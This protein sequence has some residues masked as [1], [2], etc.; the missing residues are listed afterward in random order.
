MVIKAGC[1]IHTSAHRG[2]TKQKSARQEPASLL[3]AYRPSAHRGQTD[4]APSKDG[5]RKEAATHSETAVPADPGKI[6]C[7]LGIRIPS[8]GENST[9]AP[10]G[11]L[12]PD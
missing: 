9:I 1:Y 5:V 8:G 11:V 2:Q 4:N 10:G 7:M 6:V 12:I 3:H